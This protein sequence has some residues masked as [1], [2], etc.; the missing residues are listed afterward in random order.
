MATVSKHLNG[1]TVVERLTVLVYELNA[2]L[3]AA[4][5]VH[6][7]VDIDT[8]DKPTHTEIVMQIGKR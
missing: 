5:G 8:I 6:V 3:R 4:P 7:K 2:M 1:D